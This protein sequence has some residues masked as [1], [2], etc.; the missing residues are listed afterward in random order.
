[1]DYS[2]LLELAN[3]YKIILGSKSPR[4]VSLLEE[5][6]LPFSQIIPEIEE[7]NFNNEHPYQF[8]ERLAKEK[9]LNVLNKTE[10]NSLVIGCDTIVIL[11]QKILG[12]PKDKNDALQIL[13]QLSGENHEVCTAIAIVNSSNKIRSTYELTK[14]YFNIVSKEQILDYIETGEPMDKAG[15]Y[16]I[17]GMGRFLVDRIDGNLD[18]VIGL[19]RLSLE[20]LASNF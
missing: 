13:S 10:S 7:I 9:A 17:Q 1:M 19:P 14:V 20:R 5:I 2:K 6:G 8:A 11:K 12:K 4:R 3:R 16:G 15:A 18:N